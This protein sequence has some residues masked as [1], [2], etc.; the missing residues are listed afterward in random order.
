MKKLLFTI[1]LVA[2]AFTACNQKNNNTETP[3]TEVSAKQ[4]ETQEIKKD[5][6]TFATRALEQDFIDLEGNT[7]T[8]EQILAKYKGKAILIDIWAA[9]C[10][11]CIKAIPALKEIKAEYT[12][13]VFVNLSLDKTEQ[14]WKEAIEKYGIDGE[15]YF[16]TEGKGMKGDFG[17]SLDLNW[18]PR[19]IVVDKESKIALYNATE[20]SFDEIKETLK[21][22]Q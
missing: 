6:T 9:W 17:K 10:P 18:I 7:I 15:Q 3:Q 5:N 13:T 11:D 14:A 2:F 1:A 16:S 12:E 20:K 19:Y 4:E 21:K 22:I 8:L